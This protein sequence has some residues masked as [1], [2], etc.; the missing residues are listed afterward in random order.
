MQQ[1]M[2]QGFAKYEDQGSPTSDVGNL[3]R[4]LLPCLTTYLFCSKERL[5]YLAFQSFDFGRSL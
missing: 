1:N 5:N 3:S 4:F 2:K